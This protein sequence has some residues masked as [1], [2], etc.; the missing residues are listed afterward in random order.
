ML[1][2]FL[3]DEIRSNIICCMVRLLIVIPLTFCV[4]SI[5]LKELHPDKYHGR[6][7]IVQKMGG[8]G[9]QFKSFHRRMTWGTRTLLIGLMQ[10]AKHVCRTSRSNPDKSNAHSIGRSSI[11]CDPCATQQPSVRSCPFFC[12]RLRGPRR[13]PRHDAPGCSR[14]HRVHHASPRP[15]GM[16]ILLCLVTVLLARVNCSTFQMS[17]NVC[18]SRPSSV[19]RLLFRLSILAARE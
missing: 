2:I 10:E 14:C 11:R 18:L 4:E 19:T 5:D 13:A 8:I 12:R 9:V 17:R 7:W 1:R 3:W 15:H 16:W 6:P